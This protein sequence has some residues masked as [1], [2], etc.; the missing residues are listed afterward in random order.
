MKK[1]RMSQIWSLEVFGA[2]LIFLFAF[3]LFYSL[4]LISPQQD[5][6][7][8]EAEIIARL[9]ESNP[10]FEDGIVSF[11]EVENMTVLDCAGVKEMFSTTKDICVYFRRKDGSLAI[12]KNE[13]GIN[14]I[15]SLGCPGLK[16]GFHEC[17]DNTFTSKD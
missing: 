16:V 15:R 8:K 9:A 1:Y 17:G 5:V 7:E 3:V 13:H 11:D 14:K 2:V 6:L 10:I 4:V 12:L